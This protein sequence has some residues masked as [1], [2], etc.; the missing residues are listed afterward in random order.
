MEVVGG[1]DGKNVTAAEKLR[2]LVTTPRLYAMR[3]ETLKVSS[4]FFHLASVC[5]QADDLHV[6]SSPLKALVSQNF[7]IRVI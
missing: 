3:N 1:V 2:P 6:L 4:S 7:V 5:V